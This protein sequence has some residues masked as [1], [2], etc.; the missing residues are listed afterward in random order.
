MVRKL[1]VIGLCALLTLCSGCW[2]VRVV[3]DLALAFALGIDT[4]PDN[5]E[6]I[7]ITMTN[8]AFSPK[9]ETSTA[10]T[11]VHGY[12]LINVFV[13]AQRQRDRVLVLGQVNAIVFSEE[14]ARNGKMN[15][16]LEDVD[17]Q[18]DM[19]PNTM[20]VVV[21]ESLA[22]DVLQMEPPEETR[23][24]VYLSRLL[25]RNFEFGLV[26]EVTAADFW[27]RLST[28]GIDP[29]VPVI[30]ITGHEDEKKGI[31]IVGVA[32]FDSTG[33]MK[34]IIGDSE[35]IHY[36]LLTR[37]PRR[38]RFSTKVDVGEQKSR[39]VSMYVKN[40]QRRIQTEFEDGRLAIKIFLGIDLDIIDIEADMDTLDEASIQELQTRLARDIQGNALDMLKKTQKWQSDPVGLGRFVRVSHPHWFR[41][42]DWGE[43]YSKAKIELEVNVTLHRIGTLVDPY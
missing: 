25:E 40:V 23:V 4:V 29:A 10:K 5:P 22:R 42:K 3:D 6:L 11:T 8:P 16:V 17:Q 37:Q 14:I 12:N 24:A 21:R 39:P 38:S 18:R 31:L 7:A 41:G 33:K 43:E 30:E 28:A 36:L 32:A 26:P 34:G 1:L 27:F 15:R 19:N 20:V 2:D 13:N 9:A 35:I